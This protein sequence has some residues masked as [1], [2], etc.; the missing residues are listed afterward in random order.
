MADGLINGTVEKVV[1]EGLETGDLS[2]LK[3]EDACGEEL[4]LE[5]DIIDTVDDGDVTQPF[6]IAL[7]TYY[8]AS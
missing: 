4:A 2:W 6:S 8:R 7:T 1:R 5:G 3:D